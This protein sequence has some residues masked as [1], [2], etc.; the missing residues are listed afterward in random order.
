ML[1]L[2]SFIAN[3]AARGP[4]KGGCWLRLHFKS[5]LLIFLSEC[6]AS[7]CI[8]R[9]D[10]YVAFLFLYNWRAKPKRL[11]QNQS[12]PRTKYAHSPWC[13]FFFFLFMQGMFKSLDFAEIIISREISGAHLFWLA[14][15]TKKPQ[16]PWSFPLQTLILSVCTPLLRRHWHFM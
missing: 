4:S 6:R 15:S 14:L 3:S 10:T 12:C 7:C 2:E 16:E 8:Q 13:M 1:Q 5:S 11:L 9:A